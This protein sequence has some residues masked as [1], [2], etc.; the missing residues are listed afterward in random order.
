MYCD[1]FLDAASG[2]LEK[3]VAT[4][5]PEAMERFVTYSW[6]GNLRE[7]KN[8]ILRASLLATDGIIGLNHIPPEIQ[9]S[10]TADTPDEAQVVSEQADLKAL[11]QK[12]EKEMIEKVL[13]QTK[14][15]KSETAR[16]LNIHRKTLYEKLKQYGIDF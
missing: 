16:L 15:N 14:Y 4:I 9:S 5:A 10:S 2:E 11:K 7:L 1:H 12:Q 8:I 6:P 3:D 13:R